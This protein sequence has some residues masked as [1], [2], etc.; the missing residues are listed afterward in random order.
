[1][2]TRGDMRNAYRRA[3]EEAK[4]AWIKLD[5]AVIRDMGG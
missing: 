5:C 4:A 3:K 1:V 2:F